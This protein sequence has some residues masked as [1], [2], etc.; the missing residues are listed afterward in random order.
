MKKIISILLISVFAVSALVGCSSTASNF[1]PLSPVFA[2]GV[3]PDYGNA[4]GSDS[5][6]TEAP[7]D[8][9][10]PGES[11]QPVNTV[12]EGYATYEDAY[13]SFIH[14][15][16]IAKKL[17]FYLYDSNTGDTIQV[18]AQAVQA[19]SVDFSR[20]IYA[21]LSDENVAEMCVE[22]IESPD[23]LVELN[24]SKSTKDAYEIT[25][26]KGYEFAPAEYTEE[27]EEIVSDSRTGHAYIYVESSADAEFP[28]IVISVTAQQYTDDATPEGYINFNAVVSN[29]VK[30][31]SI[32]SAE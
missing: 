1:T 12:P 30:T 8:S 18:Y 32:A 26:V 7:S 29:L 28:E 3:S 31:L 10:Q 2:N 13:V 23:A 25:V 21:E 24:I 19:E 11:E 14:P 6:V 16:S 17:D 22:F 27:G 20:N 4:G 5:A 15:E 9:E